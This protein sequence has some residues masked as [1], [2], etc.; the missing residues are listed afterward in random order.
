MAQCLLLLGSKDMI[1]AFQEW[2]YSAFQFLGSNESVLEDVF[3]HRARPLSRYF[4]AQGD[5]ILR[6]FRFGHA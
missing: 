3:N 2:G 1:F 5:E 4:L 6:E